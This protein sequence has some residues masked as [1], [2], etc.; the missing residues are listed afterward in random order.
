[1]SDTVLL[2]ETGRPT[3]SA[4]ARR[5]RGDDLIPAV[6]YGQGMDPVS[7]TVKRRDLRLALS[8]AAGANT[9]LDLT[10]DGTVYPAIVK[11]MQRH[12]VRRTVSHV[13][14]LQVNLSEEITVSVPLRLEGEA[15]EVLANNGLVDAAV[16]T[17]EVVTR[18]RDI[19][20][21]FVVDI[22]D[23]TM[24]SVIRL[25]DLPLPKGVTVT[26][27]PEM[28]VVTVLVMRGEELP[29]AEAEA[30]AEGEEATEGGAGEGDGASD[31]SAADGDATDAAE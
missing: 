29:E 31:A 21:E 6:V 2:A 18:P 28:A 26:G 17:I 20:D 8:G 14:F 12:P 1:M 5:L 3:G 13:D 23:M 19:P 22:S 25:G 7:I 30:A 11:E 10:V 24:D 27:D 9:I 16:D 4:A 15:K